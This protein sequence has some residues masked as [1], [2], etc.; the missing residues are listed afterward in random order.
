M[1]HLSSIY[2]YLFNN[3]ALVKLVCGQFVNKII[4]NIYIYNKIK[5]RPANLTTIDSSQKTTIQI[6]QECL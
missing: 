5:N 6:S 2:Q 4:Y 1:G 3:A